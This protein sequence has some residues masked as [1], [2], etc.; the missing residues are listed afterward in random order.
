MV[1]DRLESRK[2]RI[3][4]ILD[5]GIGTGHPMKQIID[6]IPKETRVVGIDIDRNYLKYQSSNHLFR[7]ATKTFAK[8]S[9]VEIRYQNFYELEQLNETYDIIIFSSSFMIMPDRIRALEIAKAC[10]K[11]NGSIFFLL[12]LQNEKSNF[13]LLLEKVKPYLKYLTTIDFGTITYER[14]FEIMINQSGLDIKYKQQVGKKS[15]FLWLFRMFV[16]ES[17]LRTR[18]E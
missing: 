3:G 4:K 7:Y 13:T 6:R 17:Q 15:I 14:D 8:H 5:V 2:N 12:T 11:P 16:V 1:A 10:L 18:E 9:N